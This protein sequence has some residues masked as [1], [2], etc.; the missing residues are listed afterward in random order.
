MDPDLV[1]KLQRRGESY[2]ELCLHFPRV[3]IVWLNDDQFVSISE[4]L[5]L[6][7]FC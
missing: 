2:M 5:L 4:F 3:C 7:V 1:R 6:V